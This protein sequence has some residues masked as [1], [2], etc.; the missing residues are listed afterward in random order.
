[1]AKKKAKAKPAAKANKALPKK[2][3]KCGAPFDG[4]LIKLFGLKRSE[5]NPKICNKCAK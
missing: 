2:C 3:E 5:K 1:M 4:F